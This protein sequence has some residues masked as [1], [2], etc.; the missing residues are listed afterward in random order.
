MNEK[1]IQDIL[2]SAM[3]S[4]KMR[5]PKN[6]IET[7]RDYHGEDKI[8][9]LI[10]LINHLSSLERGKFG[11]DYRKLGF[12]DM[13]EAS[14]F[15][16]DTSAK[17]YERG[18]LSGKELDKLYEDRDME[19]STKAAIILDMFKRGGYDYQ[20]GGTNVPLLREDYLKTDV[21]KVFGDKSK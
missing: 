9:D 2:N 19:T 16:E 1:T 21:R 11:Q 7:N 8:D 10:G 13:P 5:F 15:D 6:N 20:L 14:R 3:P 18:K 12:F 17:L 4:L